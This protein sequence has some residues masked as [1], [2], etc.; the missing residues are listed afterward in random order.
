LRILY[1]TSAF[2]FPLFAGHLRYWHFMRELGRRHEVTLFS[3]TGKDYLPEHG[4]AARGI[5]SDLRTFRRRDRETLRGR[6]LKEDLRLF[7]GAEPG[8]REMR[9][10]AAEAVAA[11]RVDVVVMAG[12][13]VF[14]VADPLSIPIVADVCDA[15][16]VRFLS[17]LEHASLLEKPK[18]RLGLWTLRHMERRVIARADRVLFASPRDRDA[19]MAPDDPRAVIVPNGV[20]TAF[21]HRG[22]APPTRDEALLSLPPDAPVLV[23]TGAMHYRPNVDAAL[24]LARNI[25]PLVRARV[26]GA[27]LFLVG[28]DPVPAL[29]AV[30]GAPGVTV[31]GQVD[32][33]RPYLE[34]ASVFAAPLRYASGI[35]N[36]VLE[37]MAME[38]PVVTTAAAANGL[39]TED[40][41]AA[42]LDVAEQPERIAEELVAHLTGKSKRQVPVEE[43]R[44]FV[45]RHFSWSGHAATL[46]AVLRDAVESRR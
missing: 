10:A 46:E 28:R 35:Q 33:V 44:R 36:K 30:N 37:A 5:V 1:L 40:G 42:P 29:R 2:P 17:R 3:L 41:E 31:T 14:P 4:D 11:G 26:P 22:A 6:V 8:I 9:E 43:A 24:L 34:R 15:E 38:L 45:E 27:R 21:W 19:L 13:R 7:W 39:Y 25:F 20:D 16:S 18:V 23:F 32:D 12:K